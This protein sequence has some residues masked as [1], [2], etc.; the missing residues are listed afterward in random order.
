MKWCPTEFRL[1]FDVRFVYNEHLDK[2]QVSLLGSEVKSS[3]AVVIIGVHI[4][5]AIHQHLDQ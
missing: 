2:G 5:P 3:P 1:T 4:T